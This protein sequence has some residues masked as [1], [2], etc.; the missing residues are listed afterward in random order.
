MPCPSLSDFTTCD[1]AGQKFLRIERHAFFSFGNISQE[2]NSKHT[3]N[4]L[5]PVL[6]QPL[7]ALNSVAA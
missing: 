1:V 6:C 5:D 2:L 3:F 7:R 4:M